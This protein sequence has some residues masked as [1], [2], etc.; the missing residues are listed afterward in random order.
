VTVTQTAQLTGIAKP[1]IENTTRAGVGHREL[2]RLAQRG[3]QQRSGF[4]GAAP[5]TARAGAGNQA[6]APAGRPRGNFASEP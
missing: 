6:A 1:L 2:L 4:P 5:A 3:G